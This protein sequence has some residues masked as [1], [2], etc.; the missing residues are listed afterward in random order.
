MKLK[1]TINDR[2][3]TTATLED[4]TTVA[5]FKE[6]LP[7]TM[8]MKD[9]HGNEKFFDLP[10][11]LPTKDANPKTIQA[12]DLM[13]WSSRTVVLFYKSFSTPYSYTKLGRIDDVSGLATAVGFGDAKVTFEL[14]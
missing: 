11:M 1:I 7:L 10:K 4:N 14:E 6:M 5:A 12:G 8:E 2:T 13:I 9:L 3:V